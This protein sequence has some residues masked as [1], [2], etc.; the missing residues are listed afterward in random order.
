M[1]NKYDPRV[2]IGIP[3]Y[4]RA[5]D[6]LK[7]TLTSALNQTYE[8]MEVIVSDNRSTDNTEAVVNSFND[9]RIRYFR[10]PENIG[11]NNNFNFCLKQAKGEYFLLLLDD[12]LIDCDFI[13]T[14]M[15]AVNNHAEIGIIRTGSRVIDSDGKLLNETPNT[16]EGLS[17]EEFFREWFAWKTALYLCSTVFHTGRLRE[18]GGFQ[19]KHNLF[20][21]VLAEFQLAEKYGRIDVQ[22]IKASFRQHSS[23]MTSAAKVSH[24][25]EDSLF[26]LDSMC[27]MASEKK[28]LIRKE[29]L[30]FFS[31]FNCELSNKIKS[32][33]SRFIA[34]LE[35]FKKFKFVF[36]YQ[37]LCLVLR[38]SPLYLPLRFIKRKFTDQL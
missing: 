33:L 31:K 2:T 32:S 9:S 23:A 1:H 5:D 24:W 19:S 4:N 20:Q 34:Y 22:H 37:I 10:Q 26:L 29:G 28:A 11:A 8:N 7:Q 15:K 12:D 21:D 3:T 18:I 38:R 36:L 30:Y 17:T 16:V 13:E 35:I 6:Y 25:C 27:D 14:C